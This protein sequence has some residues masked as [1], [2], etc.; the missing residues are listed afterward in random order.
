MT[1][2]IPNFVLCNRK[3]LISSEDK[4]LNLILSVNQKL[5]IPFGILKVLSVGSL[6]NLNVALDKQKWYY[7][8][9]TGLL[10]T[11]EITFIFERFYE[12][13]LFF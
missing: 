4:L 2:Q 1:R 3:N 11:K 8:K 7:T 10:R 12:F 13:L 9:K 5:L 6:R